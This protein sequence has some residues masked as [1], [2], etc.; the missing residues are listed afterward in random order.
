MSYPV[1]LI[2]T[3][4][5]VINDAVEQYKKLNSGDVPESIALH[6][7]EKLHAWVKRFYNPL[8]LLVIN[9]YIVFLL[10]DLESELFGS[11]D[12]THPIF[13]VKKSLAEQI[14][15][16]MNYDIFKHASIKHVSI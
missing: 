14:A 1:E 6:D 7:D 3:L 12:A 8:Q 5:E 15:K 13:L 9:G 16:E 2:K 10:P 4:T 11:N